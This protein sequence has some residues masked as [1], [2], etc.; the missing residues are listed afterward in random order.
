M[1]PQAASFFL[2]HAARNTRF[3]L[4]QEEVLF[5]TKLTLSPDSDL[6]TVLARWNNDQKRLYYSEKGLDVA[7]LHLGSTGE[8]VVVDPQKVHD[9]NGFEPVVFLVPPMK[10]DNTKDRRKLGSSWLGNRIFSSIPQ[11]LVNSALEG[12]TFFGEVRCH[13][14]TKANTSLLSATAGTLWISSYA[15]H[16]V[17]V[18]AVEETSKYKND[19]RV[20][21]I[22]LASITGHEASIITI[23][24]EQMSQFFSSM[25]EPG[26]KCP[27]MVVYK[28]I[29]SEF[30][31]FCFGWIKSKASG[32]YLSYFK[33]IVVSQLFPR[34]GSESKASFFFQE[35]LE[36][37]KNT[38]LLK[39]YTRLVKDKVSSWAVKTI[40]WYINLPSR[41]FLVPA[42]LPP[43]TFHAMSLHY[44]YGKLPIISWIGRCAILRSEC[45]LSSSDFRSAIQNFERK[46]RFGPE[47]TAL[48]K[49]LAESGAA[50]FTTF[51]ECL[52]KSLITGTDNKSAS[53]KLSMMN[54][55]DAG[56]SETAEFKVE[57]LTGDYPIHFRHT[58][59]LSCPARDKEFYTRC[60]WQCLLL[61][62]ITPALTEIFWL[63]EKIS[64]IQFDSLQF[65]ERVAATSWRGHLGSTI[66]CVNLLVRSFT[67]PQTAL[68]IE[69]S[70]NNDDDVVIVSLLQICL[71]HY[72][73]TFNGFCALIEKEWAENNFYWSSTQGNALDPKPK[74]EATCPVVAPQFLFFLNCVWLML[75]ERGWLFQFTEELLLFL[76]DSSS[77]GRFGTFNRSTEETSKGY[78]S[79]WEF[80]KRQKKSYL[81]PFY[82]ESYRLDPS[83]LLFECL[84]PKLPIWTALFLRHNK[85][86]QA[87]TDQFR[88]YIRETLLLAQRKGTKLTKI[89]IEGPMTDF[90][91]F[92]N[93]GIE[94]DYSSFSEVV[95]KNTLITSL[96]KITAYFSNL[97]S[98]YI[99]NTPLICI[100]TTLP[101]LTKLE[102][103]N[104][105]TSYFDLFTTPNLVSLIIRKNGLLCVP[106]RVPELT[107]LRFLQLSDNQIEDL[108]PFV[109]LTNLTQLD[110]KNNPQLVLSSNILCG[111]T[112]LNTLTLSGN[113]LK[114]VPENMETLV[115][116]HTLDL[117]NNPLKELPTFV[118]HLTGLQRLNLS[119]NGLAELPA[120]IGSLTGLVS[121]TLSQ[122]N[123]HYIW[124]TVFELFKNLE[125]LDLSQNHHGTGVLPL[126]LGNCTR[127]HTLKITDTPAKLPSSIRF[128]TNLRTLHVHPSAL[129]YL[130][131]EAVVLLQGECAVSPAPI[132]KYFRESIEELE[133]FSRSKVMI[134]GQENVGKTTVVRFLTSEWEQLDA[135]KSGS[136]Q[137]RGKKLKLTDLV[138]QST[139]GI[140]ISR[141]VISPLSPTPKILLF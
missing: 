64:D 105:S 35:S 67:A 48:I 7:L 59:A 4:K 1:K 8:V 29:M 6:A 10:G 76:A 58:G 26:K 54:L 16:F 21:S 24:D 70:P 77:N 80:L 44:P 39:E 108:I 37:G 20:I 49:K 96:S 55:S 132:Q 34:I 110:L 95:I 103:L 94:Y 100:G 134:L 99:E 112:S 66:S 36:P 140:H 116:L 86:V 119:N 91:P 47:K 65:Y 68:I 81:N 22:P 90:T 50:L 126:L 127:L 82:K 42:G 2:Y 15:L 125:I 57:P 85:L 18:L 45:L 62:P 109:G 124:E 11:R 78:P 23:S 141:Y 107:K 115:G 61:K 46:T 123:L 33:K 113:G 83:A 56:R 101:S 52:V 74:G 14:V 9:F 135:L 129:N 137:K 30:G 53:S 51:F 97:T 28:L 93:Y 75:Q 102:L 131:P 69:N 19:E 87:T 89:I 5:R 111:L 3:S 72:Y 73:R 128:L 25:F 138:N 60:S 32:N 38:L 12:E 40:P 118:P 98:L 43:E 79:V 88:K 31:T 130:P 121:L 133:P 41:H 71:D 122:N 13:S 120:T 63:C 27:P 106:A 117:S 136:K 104:T 17:S 84:E 114:F 139:D 92:S